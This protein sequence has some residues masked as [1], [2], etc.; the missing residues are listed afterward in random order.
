M[1]GYPIGLLTKNETPH[2]QGSWPITELDA[3]G[4]KMKRK[5]QV[6][7]QVGTDERGRSI[8]LKR[9]T[10]QKG[11]KTSCHCYILLSFDII[12]NYIQ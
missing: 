11:I 2:A 4:L 8:A 7:P 5:Y 1:V 12:K 10:W 3:D 9:P 6:S